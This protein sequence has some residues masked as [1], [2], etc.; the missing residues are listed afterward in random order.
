M[1]VFIPNKPKVFPRYDKSTRTPSYAR[2][3]RLRYNTPNKHTANGYSNVNEQIYKSM[4][5]RVK[6]DIK[7]LEH[8]GYF[9]NAQKMH[10]PSLV[11]EN[12]M[13]EYDC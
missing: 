4:S 12:M 5:D 7:I 9:N 6:S 8:N 3:C 1:K 10:A 11:I 13:F 2:S